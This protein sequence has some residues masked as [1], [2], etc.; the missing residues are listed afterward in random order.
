MSL[1]D[2]NKHILGCLALKVDSGVQ[3]VHGLHDV[4]SLDTSLRIFMLQGQTGPLLRLAARFHTKE[5]NVDQKHSEHEVCFDFKVSDIEEFRTIYMTKV[6]NDAPDS[7]LNDA[8]FMHHYE[9]GLLE[10]LQFSYSCVCIS[11]LDL[12]CEAAS[13]TQKGIIMQLAQLSRANLFTFYV[14][15][16]KAYRRM[17][18]NMNACL[19]R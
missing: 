8:L 5:P 2:S 11:G 13:S 4:D 15:R 16:N 6:G 7:L 18:K 1:I 17:V 3:A 14:R 19:S 9:L 10:R 12:A